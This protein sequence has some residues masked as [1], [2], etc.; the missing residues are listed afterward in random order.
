MC[1]SKVRVCH[2]SQWGPTVMLTNDLM[3]NYESTALLKPS[4]LCQVYFKSKQMSFLQGFMNLLYPN[5]IVSKW[6]L[7]V[8]IKLILNSAMLLLYHNFFHKT[9]QF[10][11]NYSNFYIQILFSIYDSTCFSCLINRILAKQRL[12]G[13]FSWNFLLVTLVCLHFSGVTLSLFSFPLILLFTFLVSSPNV[14]DQFLIEVTRI[15]RYS[16]LLFIG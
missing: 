14:V 11:K 12:H 15:S 3:K 6:F 1:H 4:K 13:Q 5:K 16:C 7:F 10:Y 2:K 8:Y 9:M